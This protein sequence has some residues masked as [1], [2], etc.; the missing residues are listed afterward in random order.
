MCGI[1]GK[2]DHRH[3][4]QI[5]EFVLQRDSMFL[6]GPD[7]KGFYFD[8][9][10]KIA[11]GYRRLSIVDLSPQAN[12]PMSNED[13]TLF[14]VCNGE[15]YNS[16][17]IRQMLLHAGHTF[18]SKSDC[19]V[20]LH[21]YE[22]WGVDVLKRIDGMFA[23]GLWDATKQE[24]L[25]ARDRFGIKPLYYENNDGCFTFASSLQAIGCRSGHGKELSLDAICDYLTYRY[26]PS[27]KTIYKNVEKLEPAHYLIYDRNSKTR[28]GCYWNLQ[29]NPVIADDE[30]I[31]KEC[32]ILLNK[33]IQSHLRSDV[34]VGCF[35]SGGYD[36]TVLAMLMRKQ[37][38]N[39]ITFSIGFEGWE[40]SELN[41][42][43]ITAQQ[44]D[45]SN[46]CSILNKEDFIT[47]DIIS[48]Y[49]EP[50]AD[51]SI[52]PTFAISHLA[53]RSVKT[54]FSGEGADELFGG[55]DWHHEL[56][57][58]YSNKTFI[59]KVLTQ[60]RK[61]SL[62]VYSQFMAMGAF[63]TN[64]LRQLFHTQFHNH[65]PGDSF[66]FYKRHFNS[67]LPIPKCL[68]YLDIK[69]FMTELVLTKVDR[70]SM[71][72][73]LEVRVPYLDKTLFE[74]VFNLPPEKYF[75]PQSQKPLLANILRP[76]LGDDFLNRKKQGFVGPDAFY[77]HFEMYKLI[78]DD[79]VL[80]D[81]GIMNRK[82]IDTL[83]TCKDRWR[84]WKIVILELWVQ[85]NRNNI[86]LPTA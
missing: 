2:I 27:P 63:E 19:E 75:D 69:T 57:K 4:V 38:Y 25:I 11:L 36:S 71:A 14:L 53:S 82:Y 37:D 64:S 56:F 29:Y 20:I 35:L 30:E 23:M 77:D 15:I 51:I 31:Q 73:S 86:N 33:S 10:K 67:D 47:D 79:S 50:I 76:I 28:I 58:Q 83:L 78:M 61:L 8:A 22:E 60:K 68:Q 84:L 21:G 5:E 32:Q 42:A 52:I 24:L 72:N 49:D 81:Q 66:W 59:A 85:K 7:D 17:V 48:A 65:I 41:Q 3:G 46:Q 13:E 9:D 1:I 80:I 55:Y 34:P 70:A 39:P 54:V 26:V 18:K 43:I 16:P 44:L 6:R 45:L 74:F 12:Q 40:G 62:G